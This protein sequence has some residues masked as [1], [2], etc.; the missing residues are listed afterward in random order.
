MP[1]SCPCGSGAPFADCCRPLLRGEREA[2]T[3]Q[4]LMR[5]RYTAFVRRDAGYLLRTWAP[6]TRP[7]SVETGGVTWLG[8]EV[9]DSTSGEAADAAGTVTFVAHFDE[10]SGPQALRET[11]TFSRIDGR[12]HYVDGVHH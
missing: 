11:S 6:H 5:S 10:G 7:G 8:L 9:L 3:A 2:T 4:A 12:W 1:A